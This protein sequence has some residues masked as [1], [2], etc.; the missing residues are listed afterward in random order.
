MRH[1]CFL[2]AMMLGKTC[3]FAWNA[4]TI[5]ESPY[6]PVNI[7][8]DTELLDRHILLSL[9]KSAEYGDEEEMQ[10]WIADG[11]PICGPF[12]TV[13]CEADN[14]T[15]CVTIGTGNETIIGYIKSGLVSVLTRPNGDS[16]S[17]FNAPYCRDKV[18]HTS[19]ESLYVQI[20][21]K[22][23]DWFYVRL[24]GA[25]DHNIRGWLPPEMQCPNYLAI[26]E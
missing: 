20:L 16:F 18:V 17:L 22:K 14:N 11:L 12:L 26:C 23:G 6:S 21:G 2:I 25:E 9:Y 19:E 5:H 4:F 8:Y 3:L 13:V 7:Y 10:E 1:L 15:F 24:I